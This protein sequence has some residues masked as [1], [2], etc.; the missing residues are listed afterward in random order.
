MEDPLHLCDVDAQIGEFSG[1]LFRSL[2]LGQLVQ[3]QLV[4]LLQHVSLGLHRYV[5]L[6]RRV[7]SPLFLFSSIGRSVFLFNL[8]NSIVI[9][10][11]GVSSA[12][13][14]GLG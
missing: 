9:F 4:V 11:Q 5:A 13:S 14:P 7:P 6:E 3:L 12:R 1:Q 10:L 2:V 8:L